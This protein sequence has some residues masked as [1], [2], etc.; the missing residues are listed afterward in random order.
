[1]TW[2]VL[3]MAYGTASGLDDVRRY[4][5]HI[6][7]GR[8]P[9]T[10]QLDNLVARYEAIGGVSPLAEITARTSRGLQAELDARY[11]RARFRV[12]QGMKH[13]PPFIAEAV[14]EM[15]A[16]GIERAVA[17]VLA[18]HF[19]SMSVGSYLD[20]AAKTVAE[21]GRPL[22]I[23]G[24][25]SWAAHPGY[26]TLLKDRIEQTRERFS[27]KE[28]V[29]LPIIFTAHSLPQ[30]ILRENDPYPNELRLTGDLVAQELGTI[31]YT[32]CWQS[33]GRTEEAWLEPDIIDKLT[34]MKRDGFSQAL[35]CPAG[36]VSDHLEVLYDLDIQAK[37]HARSIGMHIERTPSFNDDP[38][39]VRVLADV[40]EVEAR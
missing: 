35:I 33:A 20:E 8:S 9:S 29:N 30:K 26:I 15:A 24:V 25:R 28:R 12:Y 2:G 17:I 14:H 21:V 32:F 39:F 36:F 5:T 19:S 34:M 6:R 40:I 7:H 31:D 4:Y 23:F 3:I 22:K 11:G 18:P 37:E 27:L 10:T 16:D 38:A 1:M 13:S